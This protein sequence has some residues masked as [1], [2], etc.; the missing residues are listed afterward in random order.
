[1]INFKIFMEEDKNV[2]EKSKKT[3]ELIIEAIKE[4]DIEN[5]IRSL[6]D[7]K[8]EYVIQKISEQNDNSQEIAKQQQINAE[9]QKQ[10]N[11][12]SEE[13]QQLITEK[14]EMQS[15][16]DDLTNEKDSI[17]DELKCIKKEKE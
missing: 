6:F 1:M 15:K 14:Q 13:K 10:V 3:K 7:E 16:L 9:L 5:I 17:D 4:S 12:L 2:S 11:D 8:T